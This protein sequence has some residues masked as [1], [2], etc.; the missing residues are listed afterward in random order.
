NSKNFTHIPEET[1]EWFDI[2]GDSLKRSAKLTEQEAHARAVECFTLL[3][4]LIDTM[5]DGEEIVFADECGSWMIPG[6]EK[7]FVQAYVTSLAAVETPE[8]FTMTAVPLIQRDSYQSFATR[9]Y[10]S[11]IR[12]ANKQQ[13][14]ALKAELKRQN[15]RTSSRS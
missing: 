14:A 8:G 6:D 5:E 13:S 12:A 10:T 7:T 3:Y 11:A 9:A 2:L 15:I 4:E 1:E